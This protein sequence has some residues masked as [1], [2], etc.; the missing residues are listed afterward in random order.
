[1]QKFVFLVTTTL[2]SL[3][4]PLWAG[5]VSISKSWDVNRHITRWTSS[6][7]RWDKDYGFSPYDSIGFLVFRD[8][9]SCL[10]V[11]GFFSN[12]GVKNWYRA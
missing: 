9:L 11:K 10:W 8:K 1:L 4:I 7:P 5:A 12:E 3:A 2:L 6:K